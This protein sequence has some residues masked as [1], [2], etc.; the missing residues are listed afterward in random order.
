MLQPARFAWVIPGAAS[1]LS[2][3]SIPTTPAAIPVATKSATCRIN[4]NNSTTGGVPGLPTENPG[5]FKQPSYCNGV[6]TGLA[7]NQAGPLRQFT[8]Q[9]L[10]VWD[11]TNANYKVPGAENQ[12]ATVT[13]WDGGLSIHT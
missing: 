12:I 10:R 1:R 11:C 13:R 4:I 5:S 3:S 8:D 2:Y 9:T 7:P 6:Y